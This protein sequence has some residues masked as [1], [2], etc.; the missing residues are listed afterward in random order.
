M[1][2]GWIPHLIWMWC[3]QHH[4][5]HIS[6]PEI[7]F[8]QLSSKSKASH[9]TVMQIKCKQMNTYTNEIITLNSKT[10]SCYTLFEVIHINT[11]MTHFFVIFQLLLKLPLVILKCVRSC[12]IQLTSSTLFYQVSKLFER[13]VNAL[14]ILTATDHQLTS[15]HSY[16]NQLREIV[17]Q[18]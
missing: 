6:K 4:S 14:L 15:S 16:S 13:E 11:P 3:K 9:V 7:L 8:Y 12:Y 17:L 10:Y 2:P 1:K 18:D 5:R